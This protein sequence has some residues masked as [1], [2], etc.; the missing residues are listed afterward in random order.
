MRAVNAAE[1]AGFAKLAAMTPEEI[2]QRFAMH[3]TLHGGGRGAALGAALGLFTGDPD[4]PEGTALKGLAG[5]ATLGG[6]G[7]LAGRIQGLQTAADP[8]RVETD[9]H[10]A[11]RHFLRRPGE[12]SDE[13]IYAKYPESHPDVRMRSALPAQHW[14][15]EY[16]PTLTTYRAPRGSS[17]LADMINHGHLPAEIQKAY[18]GHKV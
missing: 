6:A 10:G 8:F 4:D 3:G 13:M 14:S 7:A 5:A 16:H 15:H 18:A 9:D 12:F 11:V 1:V 2:R 17:L